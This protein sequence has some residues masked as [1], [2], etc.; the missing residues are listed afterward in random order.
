MFFA[1]LFWL[2]SSGNVT[3]TTILLALLPAMLPSIVIDALRQKKAGAYAKKHARSLP[4]LGFKLLGLYA[5]FGLLLFI[6]WVLPEYHGEFYARFQAVLYQGLLVAALLAVPYFSWLDPRMAYPHDAH[7]HLGLLVCGKR[8][9]ADL[10]MI[11]EHMKGWA[12]KG[13]FLPLM[14]TYLLQNIE[15]L[16]GFDYGF[17]DYLTFYRVAYHLMFSVDLLFACTG[18]VMTLRLFRTQIFSAEPTALGWLVCIMCYQPFWAALFYSHYFTYDDGYYWDHFVA[19][20]P[21]LRIV[22]GTAI[23]ACL[24]MYAWATLAFGYRFSN[25]TYRGLITSGPYR[26]TK[27]PAYVF[28]CTSWWLVS[29]PF[30]VTQGADESLRQC[31]MLAG[32]CAVYFVRARTEENHLSNYPEYVAYAEAMNRRSLFA[33]LGRHCTFF[34]YVPER[35]RRSGSRVY[36]PYVAREITP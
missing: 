27:H 22:W 28:K 13:F 15:Q 34:A 9:S 32:L 30:I 1:C 24:G 2:F 12:I 23:L 33:I 35:A 36:A 20:A 16:A 4:R 7:Y 3:D 10:R 6:Y 18:Y 31:L 11:G 19:G 17:P 14:T 5:T 29:V 21:I 8:H 25:L 26:I